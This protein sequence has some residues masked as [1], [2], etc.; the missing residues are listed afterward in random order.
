M[1]YYGK[2]GYSI[3]FEEEPSIWK[4]KIIEFPYHGDVLKL[5]VRRT[6]N[7]KVNSDIKVSNRIS[8]I[9]DPFAYENFQNIVYVSWM[10][11]L[12]SV[13][14]IEIDRPRLILDIGGVYN[15]EQA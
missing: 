5:N 11:S 13:E 12:W 8:I 2:V 10:G 14:N 15:G 1:K 4:S 9:A 7:D 6:G 3:T